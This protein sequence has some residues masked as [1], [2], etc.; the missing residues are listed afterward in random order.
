MIPE[1]EYSEEERAAALIRFE[2]AQ[3]MVKALGGGTDDGPCDPEAVAYWCAELE[4]CETEIAA[5]GL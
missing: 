3:K 5:M 2:L 4:Q 1:E